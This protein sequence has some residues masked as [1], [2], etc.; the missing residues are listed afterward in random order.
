[1]KTISNYIRK[2]AEKK[3]AFPKKV[4]YS[5][6]EFS[7]F[8]TAWKAKMP[9]NYKIYRFFDRIEFLFYYHIYKLI[10]LIVTL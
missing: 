7:N 10:I 5:A 4:A 3:L 8:Y 1:M 9:S 6:E 2:I